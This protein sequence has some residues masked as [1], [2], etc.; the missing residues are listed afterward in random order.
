MKSSSIC[1][2]FLT[3]CL[4]LVGL[5]GCATRLEIGSPPRVERL[6]QL[7][8]RISTKNDVL[9]ILG[10]PR[11]HGAARL[12]PTFNQQRVWLYEHTVAEG[13]DIKLT[14]LLI[15]FADDIYDGYMWFADSTNLKEYSGGKAK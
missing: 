9:L 4:A 8:P 13:A 12:D 10:E 7:T 1:S 15:F 5:Q 11:G 3:A 2:V 14:M 6:A